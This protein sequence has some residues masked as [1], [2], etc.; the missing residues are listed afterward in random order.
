METG[1]PLQSTV[2]GQNETVTAAALRMVG[3]EKER[4]EETAYFC[5]IIHSSN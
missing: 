5:M 1:F 2:K 4:K 3:E